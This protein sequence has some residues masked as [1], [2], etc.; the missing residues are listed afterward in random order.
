MGALAAKFRETGTR[1]D[2]GVVG[3]KVRPGGL[4]RLLEAELEL[5]F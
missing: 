3:A 5:D 2:F 1:F 4:V